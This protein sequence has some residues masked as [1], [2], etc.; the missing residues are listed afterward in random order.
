MPGGET[1]GPCDSESCLNDGV[2]ACRFQSLA[3]ARIGAD[4]VRGKPMMERTWCW[5]CFAEWT[6]VL[7]SRSREG[8]G[9]SA[10]INL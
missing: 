8:I 5:P 9:L 2:I 4:L 3:F 6:L 10:Q 7:R 1:I